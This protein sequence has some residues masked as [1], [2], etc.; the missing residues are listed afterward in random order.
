V[1]KSRTIELEVF[2]AYL[3]DRIMYAHRLALVTKLPRSL[4]A[5]LDVGS[6]LAWGDVEQLLKEEADKTA[7]RAKRLAEAHATWV[8]EDRGDKDG[9]RTRLINPDL[10]PGEKEVWEKLAVE[11]GVRVIDLEEDPKRRG[12]IYQALRA[13]KYPSIRWHFPWGRYTVGGVPDGLTGY[14]AYEYK[15]TRNRGLFSFMKPV[16]LAQADLYAYFFGRPKKRVQILV[17]E[18]NVTETYEEAV[19]VARANDTLTAFARVDAG[20][21]ARPPRAWKC[22]NCDFRTTCP[23]V[24]AK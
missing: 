5:L 4:K 8:Y 9:Q 24:P 3:S 1:F 17:V 11:E 20:E 7:G 12:E 2:A 22:R 15:T 19:D 16:A 10:P 6:E 13:E 23:I 14:F 18:E 21:P